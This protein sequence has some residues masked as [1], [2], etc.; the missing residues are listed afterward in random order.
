MRLSPLAAV[1]IT[2]L[3]IAVPVAT[4]ATVQSST[5]P[6]ALKM[7]VDSGDYARSLAVGWAKASKAL[8]LQL[9]RRPAAKHPAIVFDIDETA[10][11]NA[12]CLEAA[13]FALS[14]LV[15]CAVQGRSVAVPGALTLYRRARAKKVRVF[16]V[17]GAPQAICA[18]RRKNLVKQGFGSAP[19]ITCKPADYTTDSIVPYKSGARAAIE[20]A[21]NTILLNVGDQASDLAGGHA[22]KTIKLPNPFYTTS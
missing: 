1:T 18:I 19:A 10:M 9:A 21:G 14:G 15:V 12:S 6:A 2:A 22:R 11:S 16:F 7:Q 20:K 4:A 5:S 3:A 17:T 13:D 8:D